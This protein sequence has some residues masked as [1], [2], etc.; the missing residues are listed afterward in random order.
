MFCVLSFKNSTATIIKL[1]FQWS[2]NSSLG[3]WQLVEFH[4][5]RVQPDKQQQHHI[6]DLPV[7]HSVIMW[8]YP[9]SVW[10][11]TIRY[12][13]YL[14]WPCMCACVCVCVCAEPDW[15]THCRVP[16]LERST[17]RDSHRK[18]LHSWTCAHAHKCLSL[19]ST[20]CPLSSLPNRKQIYFFQK[21]KNF[22]I[23]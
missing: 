14:L 12:L 8:I 20:L 21:K 11:R 9:V 6:V 7:H 16:R 3:G 15:F 1:Q 19:I 23:Y 5:H 10:Q 2:N 18:S 17:A 4:H 13:L 22:Q